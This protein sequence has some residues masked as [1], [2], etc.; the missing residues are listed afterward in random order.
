M[1]KIIISLAV[2]LVLLSLASAFVLRIPPWSLGSAMQTAAGIA[3]KTA[4]SNYYVAGLDKQ[5]I[6]DDVV[7]YSAVANYIDYEYDEQRKRVTANMAGMA[8]AVAQYRQG[9]GCALDF[10]EYT[11]LDNLTF[12]DIP[13]SSAPWPLGDSADN[14]AA[15]KQQAL[16]DILAED[17]ELGE[18]TRALL[19]VKDGRIIAEAY[20]DGITSQTPLLGWSMGKSVTAI[21]IGNMVLNNLV[22]VNETKLFPEW[23]NDERQHISVKNL[24]QMSSGLDFDEVYTGGSE[25]TVMLFANGSAASLPLLS[26]MAHEP[27]KH[28]MYSSGTTN[29]LA[30]LY[31][32]R[33]GGTE[34]A[35]SHFYDNVLRPLNMANFVLEPDDSGV[36]VGSS[37]VYGSARDWAKLGQLML[38]DGELNGTRIFPQ[39]FTKA[40]TTPNQSENYRAYGYQ[41]WLNSGEDELQYKDIP[42]DAYLMRGSRSQVVM[43]IPSLNMVIVRLGWSPG[44]YDTNAR[45]A[46][47][48][49]SMGM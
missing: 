12:A 28:N 10:P 44:R 15:D 45:F 26:G 11:A 37:Y 48:I 7:V 19:V 5:R 40:A 36:F 4:C 33:I 29:L 3:A 42:E 9:L 22:D 47:I 24:L 6:F 35:I 21:L 34:K 2:I 16:A 46:E 20:A 49:R 8:S 27:G 38:N 1:K 31:N 43:M 18:D 25:A 23:Q 13:V 17:N 14:L 41:F 39:G 32:D 30:K